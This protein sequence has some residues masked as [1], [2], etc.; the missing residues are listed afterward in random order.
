[1]NNVALSRLQERVEMR[2]SIACPQLSWGHVHWVTQMFCSSVP[3]HKVHPK[4]HTYC[5]WGYKYSLSEQVNSRIQSLWVM[6]SDHNWRH[7]SAFSCAFLPHLCTQSWPQRMPGPLP[8][9][10]SPLALVLGL[11]SALSFPTA[12]KTSGVGTNW[13]STSP[14]LVHVSGVCWSM[15]DLGLALASLPWGLEWQ[16][17]AR[18]NVWG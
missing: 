14:C 6:R 9:A 3:V 8:W 10:P 18:L 5:F 4:P 16:P 15:E 17:E 2:Q 12:N 13:M 1:M 7:D 11:N